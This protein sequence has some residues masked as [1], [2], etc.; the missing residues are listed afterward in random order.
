MAENLKRDR[1]GEPFQDTFT[2]N[3]GARR[4]A[5]E[6][7]QHKLDLEGD[8]VTGG[9]NEEETDGSKKDVKP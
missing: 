4:P 6:E 3:R 5:I 9:D 1:A 8:Q 7:G 2:E